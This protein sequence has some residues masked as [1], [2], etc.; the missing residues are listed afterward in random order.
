MPVHDWTRVDDGIFHAFHLA[1]L[2]ELQKALN[3]GVSRLVITPW[4]SRSPAP[5]APTC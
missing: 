5:L 1:W 4:P 3:A 2:S